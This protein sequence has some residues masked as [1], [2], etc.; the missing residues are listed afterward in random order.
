MN[1]RTQNGLKTIYVLVMISILST[2][3][4]PAHAEGPV[5]DQTI[6]Q[7]E[8]KLSPMMTEITDLI[9]IENQKLRTFGE[10]AKATT[11]VAELLA[12]Q[13]EISRIKFEMELSILKIQADYAR[14]DGRPE[15]A[16]QINDLIESMNQTAKKS[17]QPITRPSSTNVSEKN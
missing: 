14:A 10:Q 16:A 17:A 1:T 6:S 4:A 3:S 9:S 13:K 5:A 2:L 7:T 11:N 8:K 12:V 15:V